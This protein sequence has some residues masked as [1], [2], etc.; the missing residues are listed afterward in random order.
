[1]SWVGDTLLVMDLTRTWP[2]A[3]QNVMNVLFNLP[4]FVNLLLAK[5]AVI[6]SL[7]VDETTSPVWPFWILMKY[8]NGCND[9]ASA[10]GPFPP[11]TR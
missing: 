3:S 4:V 11:Q 2:P 5:G 6:L 8:N 1:M 7:R 10:Q 9:R